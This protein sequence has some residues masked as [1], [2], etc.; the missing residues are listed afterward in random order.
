MT[1]TISS[2]TQISGTFA[3]YSGNTY[4]GTAQYNATVVWGANN[5]VNIGT[6]ITTPSICQPNRYFNFEPVMD[7]EFT[8]RS[9]QLSTTSHNVVAF[10]SN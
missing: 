9:F 5:V 4:L 10:F 7:Y 6:V 1:V 2:S 8:T 3:C